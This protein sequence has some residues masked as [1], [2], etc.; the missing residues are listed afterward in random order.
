MENK[1]L[2]VVTSELKFSG[3]NN[4]IK[5]LVNELVENDKCEVYL[6]S[7]RKKIDEKYINSLKIKREKIYEQNGISS[8]HHLLYIVY[9]VKPEIV[10]THGI[11]A[12]LF[13][14]LLSFFIGFKQVATIHNIPHEDYIMRYGRFFGNLMIFFHSFLF[15]SSRVKKISV[16]KHARDT[17]INIGNAKN[18]DFIYNGVCCDEYGRNSTNNVNSLLDVNVVNILF[19]GHLTEIKNPLSVASVANENPSYKFIMLGDGP[20]RQKIESL[21]ISNLEMKGR[22]A[23]VKDYLS[24][25]DVF[26]MPSLTE[27]MPMALIEAMLMGLPIV[28]SDIPIFKELSNIPGIALF[29]FSNQIDGDFSRK[30]NI[31]LSYKPNNNRGIALEH[32]SSEVMMHRYMEV[33]NE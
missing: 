33:F 12:D 23:N 8:L 15:K 29:T 28:C 6:A 30:I 20:L 9:K 25:A 24:E 21:S 13:V 27:G 1:K 19:C 16:S 26:I 10:N 11:R 32:F 17:L 18:V 3:P 31:A 7:L 2:L 5:Y 22:V 4:V 14:F